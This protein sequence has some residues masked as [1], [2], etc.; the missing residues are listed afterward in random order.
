MYFYALYLQ[1]LRDF[2]KPEELKP[3]YPLK[4]SILL[5]YLI[6]MSIFE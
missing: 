5:K 1:L 4:T 6:S 2:L 3:I